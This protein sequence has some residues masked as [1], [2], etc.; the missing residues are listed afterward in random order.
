GRFR[1]RDG[2]V[3]GLEQRALNG[4]L[5]RENRDACRGRIVDGQADLSIVF[6]ANQ[7]A[8]R[9]SAT[10]HAKDGGEDGDSPNRSQ[11]T[12]E[13]FSL[14][15]SLLRTELIHSLE[16]SER[17]NRRTREFASKLIES[18]SGPAEAMERPRDAGF[19][20]VARPDSQGKATVPA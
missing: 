5:Q 15:H 11:A 19:N 12:H 6:P 20:G 8:M 16:C 2:D 18:M 9:F 14:R 10:G 4:D 17:H 3:A 1:K 7:R 13:R